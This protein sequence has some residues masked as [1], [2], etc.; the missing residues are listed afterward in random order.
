MVRLEVIATSLE[1]ALLAEEGGADR[2]ELVRDLHEGGL[3]PDMDLAAQI[4]RA[5]SIPVHVMIRPHSKSFQMDEADIRTMLN[6]SKR[7]YQA[8]VSALVWGVL[9]ERGTIH[10][11]ALETLLAAAPLPVTFHRAFDEI[12]Q[13]E[14]ALGVLLAYEQIR[15][16]LTSGG[17]ASALHAADRLKALVALTAGHSLQVM[18]GAGLTLA[19]LQDFVQ[20]VPVPVVHLGTG[21]RRNGRM[22]EPVDASKVREAKSILQSLA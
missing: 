11:D 18:A 22:D 9:T 3:T 5:V 15:S 14:E 20:A 21:V 4:A 16:V 8:G 6:D 12:E 2:I 10:R 17:A 19:S 13:Q 7:A 1:D